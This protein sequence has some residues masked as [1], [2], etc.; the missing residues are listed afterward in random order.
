MYVYGSALS[1]LYTNARV[2]VQPSFLEGMPLTLLEAAAHGA[3]LV[4]SDIPVHLAMLEHDAPGQRLFPS[5]SVDGL[6][7]ALGRALADPVV[8]QDAASRQRKRV[9]EEYSW[10]RVAH[11]TEAL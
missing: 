3:P 9:I 11:E 7:Q 10:D 8:E 2:F 6:R 1:E 4:A 5:G